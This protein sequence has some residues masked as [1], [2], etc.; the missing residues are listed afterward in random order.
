[1]PCLKR[2]NDVFPNGITGAG[3]FNALNTLSPLPWSGETS[4]SN[5]SLDVEYYGNISGGKIV[6]PLID[7]IVE[8]ETAT[9]TEEN[10]IANVI[11]SMYYMKWAKL[12]ASMQFEYDPI[13][14]Y[15][16]L[17]IMTNDATVKQYGR[18]VTRT[19]NLTH[20]KSGADTLTHNT[21]ETRTDNLTHAKTGTDTLTHNTTETRTDNLSHAKTGADTLTHNTTETTTPNLTVNNSNSVYGFNSSTAVNSDAQTRTETGTQA[22]AKTGTEQ[23]GYNST[24]TDT[25]TQATAKTGTEQQGYNSTETDTGTQA[26]AESG[27][28]TS[29]RNYRLTRSGNIG[30]TTSQQMIEQERNLWLWDFFYSVVFPDIDRVMTI[31]IY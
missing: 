11:I 6:S 30:V 3:I 25:G 27:S 2:L 18:T 1:M 9:S 12:Y 15:D 5:V 16:M 10:K 23:Q 26:N 17:E 13:E 21:T 4:I 28:D 8:G 22:L 19:D 14:N 20:A 7:R 31:P 24:E 29:T